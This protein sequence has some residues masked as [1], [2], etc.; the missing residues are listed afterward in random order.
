[1]RHKR[2]LVIDDDPLVRRTLQA[3]LHRAGYTV[4]SASDSRAGMT[5]A[6]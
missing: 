6:A 3:L 4:D 1:M 2:I 5:P